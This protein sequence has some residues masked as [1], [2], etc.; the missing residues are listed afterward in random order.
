MSTK[1]PPETP[2]NGGLPLDKAAALSEVVAGALTLPNVDG[3]ESVLANLPTELYV[4]GRLDFEVEEGPAK[5][6]ARFGTPRQGEF[7]RCYPTWGTILHCLKDYKTGRLVPVTKTLMQK[8]TEVAAAA[9]QYV[10][11]LAVI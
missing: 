10:V 6:G 9:R 7:V 2:T 8:Y 4:D 5:A 3:K 1:K 11:R